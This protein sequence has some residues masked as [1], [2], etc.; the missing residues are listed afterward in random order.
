MLSLHKREKWLYIGRKSAN[1]KHMMMIS[2]PTKQNKVCLPPTN[3]APILKMAI[4]LWPLTGSDGKVVLC[5]F[6][7]DEQDYK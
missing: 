4:E 6:E 3:N 1:Y 5:L 2:S 7:T